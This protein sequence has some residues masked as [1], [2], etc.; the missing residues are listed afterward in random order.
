MKTLAPHNSEESKVGHTRE[1]DT[2]FQMTKNT[3]EAAILLHSPMWPVWPAGHPAP[4]Y[5]PTNTD[6][7][8]VL[9][10]LHSNFHS[11]R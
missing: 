1:Y 2:S 8:R 10:T 7:M 5:N 9:T 6:C 11:A 3:S 4:A